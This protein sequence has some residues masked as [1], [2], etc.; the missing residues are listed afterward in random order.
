MADMET[1]VSVFSEMVQSTI[2]IYSWQ[3]DGEGRLVSSNCPC[4]DLLDNLFSVG[5]CK[6]RV[7]G[8]C[9]ETGMPAIVSDPLALVWLA[10]PYRVNDVL[11]NVHVI[12]PVFSSSISEANV[13]K[14]IQDTKIS[15]EWKQDLLGKLI[16]LP[17]VQHSS[18]IQFGLMLH[19]C[20]YEEKIGT[21][22]VHVVGSSKRHGAVKEGICEKKVHSSY[23]YERQMFHAVEI[24]NIHYK[25]PEYTMGIGTLSVGDPIRQ[26]K[27]EMIVYVTLASRA[28]MAGGLPEEIGYGIS[29]TYFQMIES[30]ENISDL[31]QCGAEAY[32]EYTQRVHR[33]KLSVGRS[34]EIQNCIAYIENH[35]TEKIDYKAMASSLGYSRNYL[36]SKF[37]K[38][39]GITLNDYIVYQRIEQAKVLLRNSQRNMHDIA[40]LL[41]FGSDSYFSTIFR[42]HVGVTP[43]DYRNAQE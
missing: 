25:K 39:M 14:S 7:F 28:A 37:K 12:G 1:R 40:F 5:G 42:K 2:G 6:Q 30:T 24:G 26:V 4:A 41:Q 17:V 13:I 31:Y 32:S 35:L 11:V 27:N 18:F 38:E 23:A 36:S 21:P 9:S 16:D 10:V 8:A 33:H 15:D 34:R 20:I 29:D 3:Y 19:Y 43:S 22:D